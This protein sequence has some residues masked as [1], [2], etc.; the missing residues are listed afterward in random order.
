MNTLVI[1]FS[2]Y[3]NTQKVAETIGDKCQGN[4]DTRV[5]SLAEITPEDLVKV[6]L[7]IMGTPTHRMNL[8][9]DTRVIFDQL[10][11]RI[12]KGKLVAAFDTSYK[13]NEFLKR[14]TA[15]KK[16]ARKLR[17][18]GGDRLVPPETFYV[19]EREGP[20]YQGEIERA[21]TWAD[22]ILQKAG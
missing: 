10:P 6:D 1:Y 9:E 5:L 13:M 4:G 16:L 12:L 8:P 7:I 2:K 20:L 14:F 15:S 22:V 17:K 11:K 19:M 21:K 3:G 18:L